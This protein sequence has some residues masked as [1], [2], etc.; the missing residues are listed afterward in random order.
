MIGKDLFMRRMVRRMLMSIR[1]RNAKQISIRNMTTTFTA[2]LI[3]QSAKTLRLNLFQAE[4]PGIDSYV[5][6]Q[7][8]S[9]FFGAFKYFRGKKLWIID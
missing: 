5:K 3:C 1:I 4:I 2:S 7:K 9:N 6:A 8:A